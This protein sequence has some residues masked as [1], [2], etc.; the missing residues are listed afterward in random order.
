MLSGSG[1]KIV[2]ASVEGD[3]GCAVALGEDI[4][5]GVKPKPACGLEPRFEFVDGPGIGSSRGADPGSGS[6]TISG[7]NQ[8]AF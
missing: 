5:N 6:T 1:C 3:V 4:A 7:E 2:S 8:R